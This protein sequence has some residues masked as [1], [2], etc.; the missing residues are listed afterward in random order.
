MRMESIKIGI[1][2]CAVID[3]DV[4]CEELLDA[5]AF[6]LPGVPLKEVADLKNRGETIPDPARDD[7]VA[8]EG[9]GD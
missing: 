6:I 1:Y 7:V 2:F 3:T 8:N 4:M 5:F 9:V